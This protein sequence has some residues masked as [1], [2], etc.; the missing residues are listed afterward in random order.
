[1]ENYNIY[2][3][4]NDNLVFSSILSNKVS[5]T[6]AMN[7]QILNKID[8]ILRCR[9][10]N[11]HGQNS[12]VVLEYDNFFVH[13]SDYQ[14]V[15]K[16][17]ELSGLVKDIKKY[18]EQESLLKTKKKKVTRK[19]KYSKKKVLVGGLALTLLISGAIVIHADAKTDEHVNYYI[20]NS[21]HTVFEY[22]ASNIELESPNIVDITDK[23]DIN[24]NYIEGIIDESISQSIVNENINEEVEQNKIYIEYEDRSQTE[25]AIITKSY[26]GDMIEK[27]AKMYGLDPMLV[28]GI[29]TQE[30]GIHSET[31]D[32]GGATGLMQIQNSVWE[33]GELS[34]YNY[35]TNSVEKITVN[36]NNLS[37]VEYN[38]KVGC[39][40]LQNTFKYMNYN[41]LAAIQCY[42][43]GYGNMQ[44]ILNEYSISSGKSMDE[45]LNSNDI[46]WL[47]CRNIIDVGDQKYLENV[48]SWI[49]DDIVFNNY[50][51]GTTIS[52]CITCKSQVK[53]M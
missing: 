3:D 52:T 9:I 21:E 49:G 43:M 7:Y 47:E 23:E 44:K 53:Q 36:I 1:M 5:R 25:K 20:N 26:Y 18:K 29:A 40:I 30:R 16:R 11:I 13:I 35:E 19:N 28:I 4:R 38:I 2:L 12:N 32:R 46:G 22:D 10:I 51:N 17:R 34:A 8:N 42:N 6:L 15:L 31:M 48:L 24:T 33:N 27:Y 39:M 37:D 41:T 50:A 14:K 45:I